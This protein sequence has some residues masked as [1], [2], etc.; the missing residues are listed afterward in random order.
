MLYVKYSQL[1]LSLKA[2]DLLDALSCRRVKL[3]F[4][5][6]RRIRRNDQ[7]GLTYKQKAKG[8]R[9]KAKGKRQKAK[10]ILMASVL[11][12]SPIDAI[13][14]KSYVMDGFYLM[15]IMED[16]KVYVGRVIGLVSERTSLG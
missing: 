12:D 14:L 13:F 7:S 8:K 5:R 15:L 11:K 9:Q 1:S 3:S 10:I 6:K 16:R 2:F 4:K